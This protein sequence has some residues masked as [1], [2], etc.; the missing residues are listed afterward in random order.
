MI[1]FQVFQREPV[2]GY[3]VFKVFIDSKCVFTH[4]LCSRMRLKS[5]YDELNNE[6]HFLSDY[7]KELK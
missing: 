4:E 7:I 3:H 6:L 5:L 2:D 1:E